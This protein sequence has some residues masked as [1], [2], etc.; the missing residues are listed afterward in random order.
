[1]LFGGLIIWKEETIGTFRFGIVCPTA[2]SSIVR[3]KDGKE[4][5]F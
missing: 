1:M 3:L 4:I 5:I 2:I